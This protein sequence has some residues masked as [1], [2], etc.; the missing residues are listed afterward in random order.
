MFMFGVSVDFRWVWACLD[1]F[2]RVWMASSCFGREWA[3]LGVFGWL[4]AGSGGLESDQSFRLLSST[5]NKVT[6]L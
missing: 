4:H 5:F 2:R 6:A 3:A 1:G